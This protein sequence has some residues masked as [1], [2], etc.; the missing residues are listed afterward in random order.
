MNT[1]TLHERIYR[2]IE[3]YILKFSNGELSRDIPRP[4]QHVQWHIQCTAIQNSC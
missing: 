2:A 1:I 4:Q 3:I